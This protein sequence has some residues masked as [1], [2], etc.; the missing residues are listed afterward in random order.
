M[1]AKGGFST[2]GLIGLLLGFWAPLLL[3]WSA[4][5]YAESPI[6]LIEHCRIETSPDATL[7][8][9]LSRL[10]RCADP[11]PR[12]VYG[13]VWIDYPNIQMHGHANE[14]WRLMFD[15]SR[16][17]RMDFLIFRADG[18]IRH[19]RYDD[20]SQDREWA[21]GAYLSVRLEVKGAPITRIVVRL[22]NA[23]TVTLVR[24]PKLMR[25]HDF[26]SFDRNRAALYGIGVGM[27]ALTILFHLTLFFAIRRRFQLIYC[28]HVTLLFVYGLCYSS[29]ILLFFPGLSPII[30]SRLLSF[31][32]AG[33][34][35]SG[36]AFVVDF[37]ER[38]AIPLVLRRWGKFAVAASAVMAFALLLM[39]ARWTAPVFVLG[40]I[41][42][43]QAMIA[44]AVILIAGCLRGSR[45]MFLL[46]LGWAL[47]IGIA[48]MYPM[49]MAGLISDATIPDG[50]MLFS[51]TLEC[52]I[53]SLP[54]ASRIRELR[55]AHERAHER[56]Q[57]LERQ[58]LTDALTGLANRRGFGHA[59]ERALAGHDAPIPLGLLVIDIDHFKRVNDRYG[60]AAGDAI[61]RH[62]AD[63]VAR[64]AGSG[65]IVAR[66]GG[67]EF[68][69]AL[70]GFDLTRAGALAERVRTSIGASFA[71]ESSLPRVTVSI[72]VAAGW[73][74]GIDPL[75]ADADRALYSAKEAGR[76]RVMLANGA[77]RHLTFAAAA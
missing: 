5:A 52:L 25:A 38:N 48:L 76:N 36:V 34:T 49:R 45:T 30:T 10:G 41:A 51:V 42:A 6:R 3:S 33:A 37:A 47:P 57:L 8:D 21:S 29:L 53:L 67:E 62:V 13:T 66:Y 63:H 23:E 17:E 28:V 19:L 71:P 77:H 9:A 46:A 31:A 61:L 44:A 18:S 68:V 32:A 60:H 35:A 12:N 43:T 72:G 22:K 56:H 14:S 27:L 75:L 26:T 55:I 16:A 2:R 69:V 15:N 39:P 50:M 64:A 7:A 40:N 20:G 59:L 4:P 74:N 1:S 58:A 73:S 65:A 24:A 54:V 11:A 70:G